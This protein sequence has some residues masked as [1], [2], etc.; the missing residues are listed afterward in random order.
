MTKI[1][2]LA[3]TEETV[4][5]SRADFQVL[6]EAAEDAADMAAV[7]Q[8]RL[9][10]ERVGQDT[11]KRS[12]LSLAEAR[13]LLDGE[14]AVRV[15]REKR[16][17][18]QRALAEAARVAVSYL[19]EIESGK[20]P[21]SADALRRLAAVLEVPMEDLAGSMP[22]QAQL[23]PITRSEEAAARLSKLAE[24]TGDRERVAREARLIVSEWLDIAGREGVQHQVKATIGALESSLTALSS[25]WV[26]VAEQQDA[27][28][29]TGAAR[30][31]KRASDALEAAIDALSA[32]YRKS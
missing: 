6:V 23:R 16:G 11:A 31:A 32:A 3:E 27:I 8:H 10:E 1:K 26:R 2:V 18:T 29:D 25:T 19:A 24:E 9:Y 20:K 7:R 30:R 17:M 21:G 22:A 12:Y 15:W 13:R 4:T 14:S 28:A 5:L